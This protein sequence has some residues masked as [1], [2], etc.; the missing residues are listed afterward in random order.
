MVPAF[1]QSPVAH[2]PVR[3]AA[4]PFGLAVAL[5]G[6]LA[7]LGWSLLPAVAL[8]LYGL[9]LALVAGATA[10]RWWPVATEHPTPSDRPVPAT[11][12]GFATLAL[13]AEN[14]TSSV[15]ITDALGRIDWV[16]DAFTRMTGYTLAEALGK[17]PGRLLQGT[18]SQPAAIERFRTGLKGRGSFE[19]EILNYHRDGRAYWV[20]MK[21]DPVFDSAGRLRHHIAIQTDITHRR[22]Q[23]IMNA[24]VLAHA[25]HC[26]VAT[27]VHGIIE[28]FNPGAVRL[29]GHAAA[30]MIGRTK[31]TALIEPRELVGHATEL[32][33][34]L[35]RVVLPGF[36]TFVLHAHET[37]E[38]EE[39]EWTF[40]H[41]EGRPVPV[42]LS[43]SA[44]RDTEGRLTGYL[45]I[46][47]EISAERQAEEHRREFDLR[48]RK[49]A[50]QVPGMVFQ[51]R[52]TAD[53]RGSFPYASEGI[54]EIYGVSPADVREDAG[55]VARAL[56][57]D[58]CER[59]QASIRD[60]A[61]ELG[62]WV[63]EYRTVA[64]DGAVRWVLG[65]AMPELQAD[66]AIMWHGFITDITAHRQAQE[67][68]EQSRVFLQSI[69]SSVDLAIFVVEAADAGDF[70]FIEVNPG[71]ERMTGIISGQICGHRAEDLEPVIPLEVAA[72]LQ[73]NF[74]R[75]ANAD[76]SIEYEEKVAFS[77]RP[78]WWL[79]RL[80]PLAHTG[81]R[82]VRLVGRAVNITERKTIE[83]RAQSLSE[84]LQLASTAAQIGIWDLDLT[85]QHLMWDERMHQLYGIPLGRF[86]GNFASWS[87][88]V[89]PG[90]VARAEQLFQ[91]ALSGQ[92][93]F[94]TT[95]RILR[96]QGEVRT[97]RAFAH[98]ERTSDGRPRRV[99]GVNWDITAEQQA[100]DET[101]RAKN[102][103]EQLN[104]L[105]GD[106]LVRAKD[107]AR[108]A[109]AAGTAKS[110]FLANMSHEIRTPLNAVLGMS[111]LLLT[112]GLNG[113][114]RE[115]AETIRSSGDSLLE[116]LNDI[117]DFS[118]IDAGNLELERQSF[119]LRECVE[120]AVDVLAG[121]TAEKKLDLLY[122]MGDDVPETAE[123]DVTRLRQIIV[124]L[125]GNAVKFT[126]RGEIF[127]TVRRVPPTAPGGLRLHLAVHD[128]GIGI[129]PERMDRLFKSFSQVDASTTRN[130]GG[131]GLGLA[132]CKRLVELMRGR[133]WAESEP[134]KGSVFQ[135]EVE[136]TGLAPAAAVAPPSEEFRGRRVLIVDDNPTQ[137]RVL[138]LQAVT[139][140]LVPRS[141]TSAR[142]ALG[143]L[144]RGDAFDLALVD[145]NMPEPGGSEFVAAV[146]RART[147]AQLPLILITPLGQ[148]RSADERG[149]A[150][151]ISKPIKPRALH[152][153][154]RDALLG[155]GGGPKLAQLAAD[156]NI[157]RC[158]PL[159]V[160][161]V[162]DNA[163]NQRVATLM[164]RKLGYT[165]DVAGNGLEALTAVQR[166]CYDLVFMDLQMPEMDGL[167]ATREIC[168]RWAKSARPHIVA[169]T[170]NASTG[171]REA[172]LAAGMDGFIS[173]P[174][175][176]QD[177]REVM[178]VTPAR[179]TSELAL[180]K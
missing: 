52:R 177:L 106:S 18:E 142:E 105:L 162:E 108:E 119:V 17:R 173:K 68:H 128:S 169:M 14:T 123:G 10:S 151:Y 166:H 156:E 21:I 172:C 27:D 9:V 180:A 66:G 33:T 122:W 69:Y 63:C 163:V 38:T 67:A 4:M 40:L 98:V 127:L 53:G 97:L 54:R 3:R 83:L 159:R 135:F 37:G 86:D 76:H 51:Y 19:M 8:P 171:D 152:A 34:Q 107:L 60:S 143:W 111:S 114:Q 174:V 50:S 70:R 89:H 100:Q 176:L 153:L 62:Q 136:L 164:L 165:A 92:R 64:A 94:D 115:L 49:I 113:E 126:E 168:A 178:L 48:L 32:T 121:R 132:I 154:V 2:P 11:G 85:S 7:V 96:G 170:A 55:A 139:W 56:H 1:Q 137:C 13:V 104:R 42:R 138:C 167:Q 47:R 90:D 22:R 24:G 65:K 179:E 157:A 75:C 82:V 161:L 16:N 20:Q 95:F 35:G 15:V 140:G 141:T 110:A 101:L 31:L 88:L 80:T 112:S 57:P 45:G 81:G 78:M 30:E 118:K 103:A 5:G 87:R 6:A 147:L 59:V 12:P 109:A 125:L 131:T 73:K 158:H 26:I 116:L 102:E 71:F 146:R 41:R 25:S 74:R 93:A 23:E 29:T 84:R 91:A 148:A 58:D 72:A 155:L 39:R 129:A 77:G 120:S 28:I 160:L 175:R 44:M 46:A 144:E 134:G 61:R 79:T 133:I 124:N 150:G 36:A 117:L 43:V 130:Y 149:V 99:V 145:Q